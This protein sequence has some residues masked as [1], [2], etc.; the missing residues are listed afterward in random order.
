MKGQYFSFDAIIASVIF[1]LALVA[2]LSYWYSLR[3][4]LE[5]QNGA[6]SKEAFRISNILL[7][8]GYTPPQPV[9]AAPIPPDQ[10][11]LSMTQ[12]GLAISW[13]DRRI[14]RAK[15]NC[16]IDHFT[17]NS[18]DFQRTFGTPY[19]V[20]VHRIDERAPNPTDRDRLVFGYDLAL[21]DPVHVRNVARIRR[22]VTITD[23]PATLAPNTNAVDEVVALDIYVYEQLS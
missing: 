15:F 11:C 22:I 1:I 5:L 23:N 13:D 14:D 4:S 6:V 16:V 20:S 10:S 19:H 18:G 7:T 8:P 17:I 12:L 3:S 9:G 2:L 21:A